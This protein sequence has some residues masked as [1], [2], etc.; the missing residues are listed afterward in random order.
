M[1]LAQVFTRACVGVEAPEVI[2]E[3]HLSGGLPAVSI[4]GLPETAVREARDRVKAALLNAGFEFPRGRITI[5]LAPAD[6][7]KEGSRFDLPIAL[8]ILAANNLVPARLL[9]E[10]EFVGELSLSG[11]LK[12]VRGVLPVAIEASRSGRGLVVPCGN[13]AEAALADGPRYLQADSLLDVV[14]WMAG[15]STLPGVSR[16]ADEIDIGTPDL[17]D[18]IGQQRARRAL[19]VA[20]AGGH[21]ILFTGSPGTG[22]TMLAS[23]LPGIL[24]PMKDGEALEVAAIASVSQFGLDLRRWRVRPFRAPHHTTSAIALVGG[25]SRPKPGEISLAHNGVLFLDELPEFNRHVLEVLR[26]P[27]ESGQIV[28][29]RALR[30]ETYPARFQLIAAMNPCPCGRLGEESGL[31]NCSTDQVARY[32]SRIS[33]PLLDRIDIHVEMNRPK[34][35]LSEHSGPQPEGSHRVR[36]RV[37]AARAIQQERSGGTNALLD[38]AGIKA[39]CAISASDRKLLEN[40]SQQLALS[41]RACLRILKVA[42]TLADLEDAAQIRTDHLAEAISYRH[43]NSMHANRLD[44]S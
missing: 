2:V 9:R 12:P 37:I 5:S 21:N 31:C 14:A 33:G 36:A 3:I 8:G 35:F 38:S 15:R 41:P 27:L 42:R 26:E 23:R 17:A 13:G 30:R 1:S 6:L 11:E 43:C 24:P 39:H 10:Y 44:F 34:S 4:V 40:A 29:S 28:I 32:R 18:V 7:P 16:A 19:E 20:A 25:G 22:K